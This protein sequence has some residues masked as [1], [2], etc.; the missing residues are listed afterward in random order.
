MQKLAGAA[1]ALLTA[2]ALTACIVSYP[3]THGLATPDATQPVAGICLGPQA[4]GIATF[5][6]H[7]DT[8]EPRCGQVLAAQRLRL[9]NDTSSSITVTFDGSDYDLPPGADHTF[10]PA[11]GVMWQPGV[12]FLHTS[13]YAGGGGPEIWLVAG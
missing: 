6:L 5:Q 13:F 7:I 12:H 8:P 3:P 10:E 9:F 11:F 1:L 4:G 2:I